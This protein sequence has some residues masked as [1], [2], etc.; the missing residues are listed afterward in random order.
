MVKQEQKFLF[1]GNH[2]VGKCVYE[3]RHLRVYEQFHLMISIPSVM[4][5]TLL[6]SD[7]LI[8]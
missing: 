4:G 7:L 3:I 5:L 2:N 1:I 6:H 8:G